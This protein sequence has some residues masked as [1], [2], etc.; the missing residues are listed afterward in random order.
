MIFICMLRPE[1]IGEALVV[2]MILI[3]CFEIL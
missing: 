3:F 2:S 1:E